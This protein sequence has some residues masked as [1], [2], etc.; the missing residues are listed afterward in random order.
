MTTA[1]QFAQTAIIVVATVGGLYFVF[2]S[3]RATSPKRDR[4][5]TMAMFTLAVMWS[6]I[7]TGWWRIF[8]LAAVVINGLL[9]A[10]HELRK[11]GDA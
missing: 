10:D 3:V 7:S 8:W 2:S 5:A 1:Q 11:D 4:A 6:V 9:L